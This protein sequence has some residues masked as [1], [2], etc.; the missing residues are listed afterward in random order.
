MARLAAQNRRCFRAELN[1]ALTGPVAHARR[2]WALRILDLAF[3]RRTR[4]EA[5]YACCDV[6]SPVVVSRL[7]AGTYAPTTPLRPARRRSPRRRLGGT[8]RRTAAFVAVAA[9]LGL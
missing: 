6:C 5:A 2:S 1:E 9:A 7:R 3:G 4:V 8:A